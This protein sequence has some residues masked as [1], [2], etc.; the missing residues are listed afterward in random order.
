MV[1]P[2]ECNNKF[3]RLLVESI[4][5]NIGI[6]KFVRIH[7]GDQLVQQI[8][9]TFEQFRRRRLHSIFKHLGA[10][11]RHAVPRFRLAPV[12]VVDRIAPVVLV[13]PTES[14]EA[15]AHVH[16]GHFHARYV[17]VDETQY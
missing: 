4:D 14:R 13:V 17:G 7:N 5:W 1:S 2:W 3:S 16:P 9:L 6:H 15:H 12:Q 8:R 10:V 11:A